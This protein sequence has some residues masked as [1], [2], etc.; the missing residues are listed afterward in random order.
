MKLTPYESKNPPRRKKL[1]L[2]L[3]E[4]RQ[5]LAHLQ[6]TVVAIQ[7]DDHA[8][9]RPACSNCGQACHVKD[10]WLHRVA[11]LFGH[12]GNAA[13]AISLRRPWSW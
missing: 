4:T 2:M 5:I 10:R 11:T 1:G 3:S 9:R 6:Q 8:V 13:P 7:A 12:G